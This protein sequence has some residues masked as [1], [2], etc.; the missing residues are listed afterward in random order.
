MTVA[1]ISLV[2]ASY[3]PVGNP[4]SAYV[5][6]WWAAVVRM[7]PQPAEVVVAHSDPEPLGVIAKAPP[8][9]RVVSVS[10][11]GGERIE[12][13]INPGV[14][15]ASQPWAS[16]TGIDDEYRPHALADVQAAQDAGADVLLWHHDDYETIRR[17]YW[18]PFD[19]R[20]NN[21]VHG[22]CPF[23]RRIWERVGGQPLVGWGDW[24]F[25][26]KCL[27]AGAVVYRSEQVGVLWDPGRGRNTWTAQAGDG[28]V[29]AAR[30]REIA[31][32]VKELWG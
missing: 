18:H 12:H 16:S 32:L 13:Y 1:P 20:T 31:D 30:N 28:A 29:G 22:S 21:T 8:G 17:H 5:D 2:I 6:K 15:A 14:A 7:D 11:S 24:A 25:W 4:Y 26:L 9:I 3:G 10:V 19:L 27:H 23:T